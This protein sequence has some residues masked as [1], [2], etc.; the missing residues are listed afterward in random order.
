MLNLIETKDSKT[1]FYT[2]L[3]NYEVFQ[4]LIT[5]LERKVIRARSWQ[6][7]RTRDDDN[8]IEMVRRSKV[9][10]AEE[11]LAI[12]A[13]FHFSITR[14]TSYVVL[15]FKEEKQLHFTAITSLSSSLAGNPGSSSATDT[16]I[17]RPSAKYL[18]AFRDLKAVKLSR[19]NSFSC[20]LIRHA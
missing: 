7:K 20:L 9:S 3:P 12:L 1:R 11:L 14:D 4:A 8:D 16:F 17:T 18:Y 15:A 6:G 19:S 13:H 5:Y 10:F 2:G